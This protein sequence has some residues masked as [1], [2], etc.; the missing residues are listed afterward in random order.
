MSYRCF[1]CNE[2]T[3]NT[4]YGKE[5]A[6]VYLLNMKD[7]QIHIFLYPFVPYE[8][9]PQILRFYSEEFIEIY[10]NMIYYQKHIITIYPYY[11]ETDTITSNIL[12]DYMKRVH[13]IWCCIDDSNQVFWINTCKVL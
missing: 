1:A 9:I 7:E 8:L 2:T 12:F 5:A 10:D 13:K 11:I 6:L 4:F 3:M